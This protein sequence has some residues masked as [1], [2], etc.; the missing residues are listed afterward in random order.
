MS[1]PMKRDSHVTPETSE[2]LAPDLL[3]SRKEAVTIGLILV[4]LLLASRMFYLQIIKGEVYTA[5][6]HQN[7]TRIISI[8]APRGDILDRDDNPLVT[9]RPSFSVYYWYTNR[10]D[11]E[12]T[13]PHLAEILGMDMA[14]I[15]KRVLQY[16]GRY[17]EPIPIA[18]DISPEA[19]TAIVENAPL[20]RGVFI[21]PEP[22]R[23]YPEGSLMSPILG[24][25]GEISERELSQLRDQGYRIGD[26]IGKQ[27][28]ESYYESVL[29]GKDGGYQVEVD[30][31]MRPTGN[32]GP[33][34]EPEPGHDLRLNIDLDIQRAAEEAVRDALEQHPSAKG[35]AAVVLDVKTGGVLAIVS[36]PGFDPNKLVSGISQAELNEFLSSG[37]WR[38][39]DLATTGLYPPGS[40]FKLVTAIAALCEGKTTPEEEIFDPGYHPSVPSLVCHRRWGHG[41]VNLAE[42]IRDSCNVY[43]YEMGRRLGMDTY[44][45][46]AR[47]LGL[48]AK[49]GID[50]YGENYGTVPDSAWK[51][52]AYAEGRVREPEV[53]YAEH[54][55]GAMGQVFHLDTPIQ[56]ASL[57]QAIANDG[58]RMRP[59]LVKEILTQDGEV[60][61]TFEPE[62]AGV[63]EAE[64]W[65][66]DEVKKG[67]A[68]VTGDPLGTAYWAFRDLPVKVAG[69]TGTAEN[70]LGENH[71]WFVGFGPFD[72]PEIALAVV[73]DQGGS[74]S[75]V[76]APVAR[77]IFDAYFA[78][79]LNASSE[80]DE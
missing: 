45:E 62:V 65:I 59:F 69:K 44:A 43:F 71:A 21:E 15:E 30:Y 47:A 1:R 54:M 61:Q 72:N 74:G 17:F 68:M 63:L 40:T 70:P 49:T 64:Q 8:P 42:A 57:T 26:I 55:M 56:M 77:A 58:V 66:F 39:S 7:R 14:D 22:I 53:L 27:G 41:S 2:S 28:V 19:Y 67:M 52:K 75:E 11:A 13:L 36:A 31:L 46:Y 48:G 79:R 50:L 10:E 23:Y 24:Y 4:F 80:A 25:V 32:R 34:I 38:F 29:R 5:M 76:A 20:L 18:K 73:I 35:G 3:K 37:Q 33:G 60:V 78:D 6:S 9:S 51:A 16:Q 12:K